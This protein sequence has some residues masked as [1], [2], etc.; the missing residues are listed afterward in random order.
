MEALKHFLLPPANSTFAHEWDALFAYVHITSLII[1]LGVM[2][3]AI[4]FCIKYRRRSED[5]VTPVITH[6][7]PLETVWSIIPLVLVL[8]S[9]AWGY[10]LFAKEE[11]APEEAYEI[12]AIGQQWL[13][14]FIYPNGISTTNEIHV[15]VGRPV[16]ITMNSRDVIHSLYIPTFRIKQDV[17]PG[18]YTA[19][20]FNA[21]EPDTAMVF[22]AEYCGLSHSDM[23]AT[24]YVHTK[25]GFKKW[26]ADAQGG[27][28]MPEGL[29]PAE[30]GSRLVQQYACTTCH[31]TDG[32]VLVGPSWKG[33]FGHTVELTNGQ[34]VTAD[35]NYIRESILDPTKKIVKGFLPA[36]P[37]YKGQLDNKQINAII[38]Y[39]KTL[40]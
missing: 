18:R 35:A 1:F 2:G 24:I 33:V 7:V 14:Q 15:P 23:L 26:L 11:T 3:A 20:W 36:M 12:R 21:L 16:K 10:Q 9:F 29:T 28:G 22:C 34:T 5:E 32:T 19:L 37:P 27:G 30:W 13:W 4:Y 17:L 38:E 39:I 31:T 40:K 6:N 25:E 8:I